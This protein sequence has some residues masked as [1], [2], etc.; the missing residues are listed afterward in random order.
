MTIGQIGLKVT[1]VDRAVAFYRDR[2]GLKFVLKAPNAAFFDCGGIRLV[3]APAEGACSIYLK[4]DDLESAVEQL[5]ARGISFTRAPHLVAR[6]VDHHL[7][8]AFFEDP[9]GNTLG[10]MCEKRR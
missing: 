2:V 10:L 5:T 4:V 8:M 1:D 7:W 3:L 6:M 9:D